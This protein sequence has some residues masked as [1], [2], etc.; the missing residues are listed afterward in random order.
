MK[1]NNFGPLAG[2]FRD[3]SGFL[4]RCDGI[5]YRQINFKCQENY[6]ALMEIGLYDKLLEKKLLVPHKEVDIAPE[7][8]DVAYKIIRPQYIPF[9]SYPYEWSFSQLKDASLATLEIERIALEHGMT[10]KDASAY[11]IQFLDGKPILIDTLS[12]EK[13]RLNEP[14]IAYR[15]FC[16]HFLATLALMACCDIRLNQLLR[17]YIDGVPL[18]LASSLLPKRTWANFGILMHIHLHARSQAKHADVREPMRRPQMG[19]NALL[20]LIDGLSSTV[21]RLKWQPQG[22]EWVD[23]YDQTNYTDSGLNSKKILV[24][25][26]LELTKPSSVWDLGANVGIFSRLAIDQGIFTVAFDIDPACVERNYL[27][28]VK[29]QEFNS[30]PLVLDLT[31]PSPGIGFENRERT[32]F[33]DRGPVDMVFALALLHHLAISNNLPFDRIAGFFA[34]ICDNLIIEYIPK[35][36]SQVQRMLANREDIFDNYDQESFEREFD[37]HF[38][39]VRK[40]PVKDSLRTLY[41]MRR[42]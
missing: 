4:F 23:Y 27:D 13:Y 6:E 21:E 7:M 12:F 31:N 39:T 25:E 40:D 10:L 32:S 37:R 35:E 2:S 20:G 26:Y 14:W 15:Q 24:K 36:D 22:T 5:I 30:I 3:P 19:L 9:I 33:I 16:Q 28:M 1:E 38:I 41:L 17:I 11:N 8:P 18:D 34:H 42:C 29:H